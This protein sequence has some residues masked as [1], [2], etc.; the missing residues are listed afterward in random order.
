[1]SRRRFYFFAVHSK[2][3]LVARLYVFPPFLLRCLY[4]LAGILTSPPAFLRYRLREHCRAR[5]FEGE[6]GYVN[7]FCACIRHCCTSI[8]LKR[9]DSI[10]AASRNLRNLL[11]CFLP[12][13]PRRTPTLKRGNRVAENV[14]VRDAARVRRW[15][16]REKER[17]HPFK[18]ILS[19]FGALSGRNK[20]RTAARETERKRGGEEEE[21]EG[22][23]PLPLPRVNLCRE[24]SNRI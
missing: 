8:N 13:L 7:L 5:R 2:V 1:M 22:Q 23:R 9:D 11:A 15:R 12:Q 19:P 3:F 21:E 20:S 18:A 24:N 16:R 17:F 10:S 4:L 14:G 6:G